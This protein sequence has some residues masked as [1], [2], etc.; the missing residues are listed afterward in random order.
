MFGPDLRFTLFCCGRRVKR[1]TF[2]FLSVP[3]PKVLGA[4]SYSTMRFY[5]YPDI[6]Q[7]GDCLSVDL[8]SIRIICHTTLSS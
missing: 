8:I 7:I 6:V 2:M 3:F 4:R 1:L 5:C